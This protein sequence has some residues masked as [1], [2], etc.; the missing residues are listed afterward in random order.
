MAEAEAMAFELAGSSNPLNPS[1]F[2][3]VLVLLPFADNVDL[4]PGDLP[5]DVPEWGE[6]HQRYLLHRGQDVPPPIFPLVHLLDQ[7]MAITD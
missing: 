4:G 1:L 3:E 5:G 2:V 6:A 7:W